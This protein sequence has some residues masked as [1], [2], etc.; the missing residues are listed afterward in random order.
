MPITS[1]F[2]LSGS[3][4][5]SI[6][7]PHAHYVFHVQHVERGYWPEGWFVLMWNGKQ[8]QYLGKLDDFTGQVRTTARSKADK[9]SYV[10]RLLN[11]T[12]ARIWCGDHEAYEQFGYR[13]SII[14]SE[15]S[16]TNESERI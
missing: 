2:I 11:K 1:E 15:L 12:L 9:D 16:L 3:A 5:F 13:T 10:M 7:T 4:S 6:E 14:L 8:W